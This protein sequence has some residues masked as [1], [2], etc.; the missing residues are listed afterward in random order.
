MHRPV[1][2]IARRLLRPVSSVSSTRLAVRPHTR[3]IHH[4]F[5]STRHV[6]Q[7]FPCSS[8]I[9]CRPAPMLGQIR[10]DHAIGVR[11][12][13]ATSLCGPCSCFSGWWRTLLMVTPGLPCLEPA[14]LAA[15]LGYFALPFFCFFS[16][17]GWFLVGR[18]WR[19]CSSVVELEGLYWHQITTCPSSSHFHPSSRTTD[20][21]ISNASIT[22]ERGSSGD[23]I[24]Y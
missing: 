22:L 14:R 9:R 3:I 23:P 6:L 21:D 16:A 2:D 24:S 20:Y 11:T 8:F 1:L 10:M 5:H 13:W 17:S 12:A 4:H 19:C 18:D 15:D 7:Y